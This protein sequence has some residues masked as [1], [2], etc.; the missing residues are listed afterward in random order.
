VKIRDVDSRIVKN[1]VVDLAL[2]VIMH[3]VR[4]VLGL[5]QIIAKSNA[6]TGRRFMNLENPL[7]PI[8]R[9]DVNFCHGYFLL[10]MM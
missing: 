3:G 2:G 9:D 10:L 6:A 8:Q 1:N 4:K 7:S 5:R